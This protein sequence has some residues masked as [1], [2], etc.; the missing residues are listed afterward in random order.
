MPFPSGK[1]AIVGVY[2]TEQ[3][4]SLLPRTSVS[5][6]LEAIKGALDDAG[7]QP[8]DV[9]GII[10]RDPAPYGTPASVHMFWAEQFGERPLTYLEVGIASG[11]L[12][13]AATAIGAGMANVVVLFWAKA[14]YQIGPRGTPGPMPR[15]GPA[16]GATTSTAPT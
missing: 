3:A 4:K 16:R 2:T 10:P 11:G 1:T 5:L 9:D 13:K 7:L 6:Q 14:G 12:A 8:S 15:P